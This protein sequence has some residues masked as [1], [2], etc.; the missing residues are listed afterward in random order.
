MR[1][2]LPFLLA[3]CATTNI[4]APQPNLQTL[5]SPLCIAECTSTSTQTNPRQGS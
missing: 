4:N 2:L 3:G 1:Y 5:G